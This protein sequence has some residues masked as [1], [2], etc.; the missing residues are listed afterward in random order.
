V[1][2]IENLANVQALAGRRVNL[3]AFPLPI[4]GGDAAQARVVAEI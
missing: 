2:I 4:K 1:L 3:Y